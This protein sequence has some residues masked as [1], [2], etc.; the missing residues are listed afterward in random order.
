MNFWKRQRE[1]VLKAKRGREVSQREIGNAL[2][3]TDKLIGMWENDVS[4]PNIGR[5]A[6][7]SRVYE[8][9]VEVIMSEISKQSAKLAQR[10]IKE[11][12]TVITK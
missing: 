10:R 5:A 6:D 12:K 9:P 8:Q 1:V 7:L 4:P 3:Y 11:R 2:G